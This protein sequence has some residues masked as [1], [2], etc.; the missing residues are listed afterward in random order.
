V[1][2]LYRTLMNAT[3]GLDQ[4]LSLV[5]SLRL[6]FLPLKAFSAFTMTKKESGKKVARL[7]YCLHRHICARWRRSLPH[8]S[9]T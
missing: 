3:R 1:N 7:L 8:F 5:S 9:L 6:M 4:S 2:L